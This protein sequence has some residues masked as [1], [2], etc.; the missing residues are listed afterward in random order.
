MSGKNRSR[1]RR[2]QK[3]TGPG[4]KGAIS[5]GKVIA[6]RSARTAS[7]AKRQAA[8]ASALAAARL[9]PL[10]D[11][12]KIWDKIGVVRPVEFRVS[13]VR[14]D[15]LLVCDFLF[16]NLRL[17]A[18]IAEDGS[19][20]LVRR[21]PAATATLVVELPPQSFGEQAFLDKTGPEV[22]ATPTGTAKFQ[23]TSGSVPAD[24]VATPA[25]ALGALP[26][27]RI[28][29]AGRSRIA[30]AM[31]AGET[32]LPFTLDAILE[33]CR[34]WPMRLDVNA[35]PEPSTGLFVENPLKDKAVFDKK[36]LAAITAS[37]D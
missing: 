33:A 5:G 1:Q 3:P 24:N 30:F 36:W 26:F 25:E 21:D 28:R 13:F 16:D 31:P 32:E 19:R 29:M 11:L 7:K 34:R 14:P 4:K 22:P 12:G 2:S 17:A 23:E 6:S 37:D 15:D 20:L 10:L 35:T 18:E 9:T 8:R 27:A